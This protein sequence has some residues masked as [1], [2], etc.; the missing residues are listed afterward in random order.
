MQIFF[1]TPW[2]MYPHTT[3]YFQIGPVISEYILINVYSCLHL[4]IALR[5]HVT[6]LTVVKLRAFF[7]VTPWTIYIYIY[8]Y[9]IYIYNTIYVY[10]YIYIYNICAGKI[11]CHIEN[12][13]VFP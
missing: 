11:S 12:L 7:S 10:I 2:T 1:V 3:S 5:I 8:I 4:S 13:D 9:I 6:P